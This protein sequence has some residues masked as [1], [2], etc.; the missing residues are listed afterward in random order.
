MQGLRWAAEILGM[1]N[2]PK[3]NSLLDDD[4]VVTGLVPRQPMPGAIVEFSGRA[5]AGFAHG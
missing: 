2:I 4:N 1:K 3:I 5:S